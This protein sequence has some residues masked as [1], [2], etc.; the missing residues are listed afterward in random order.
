MGVSFKSTFSA[1][2]HIKRLNDA[3]K[4]RLGLAMQDELET[5]QSRTQKG[6]GA[7]GDLKEYAPSTLKKKIKDGRGSTVNLTQTGNML[8]AMHSKVEENS[9]GLL[10]KIFF[11]PQEQKKAFW[12]IQ[13]RPNFFALSKQQLSNIV[14]RLRGK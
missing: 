8:D 2:K 12:N 11:L 1:A 5:I 7:E 10:G 13:L 14:K 6:K 9:D 4:Q 3:H